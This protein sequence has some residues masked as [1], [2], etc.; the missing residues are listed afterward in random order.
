MDKSTL[1]YL[2][3]AN[4]VGVTGSLLFF[5]DDKEIT[6]KRLVREIFGS[7]WISSISYFG[8]KHFL[9]W[10]DLFIYSICS[11]ISF[12]NSQIISFV[13]KD[14]MEA[15]GKSIVSRLRSLGK[16]NSNNDENNNNEHI[17]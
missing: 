15:I 5:S 7:I 1:I 6:K 3:I 8:F 11:I 10:S 14:L 12:L 17:G 16:S 9:I 13:G 4:F 2:G